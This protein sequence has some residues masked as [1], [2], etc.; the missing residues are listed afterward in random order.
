LLLFVYRVSGG[1]VGFCTLLAGVETVHVVVVLVEVDG[2]G[3]VALAEFGEGATGA[4]FLIPVNCI[5]SQFSYESENAHK[6]WN[7]WVREMYFL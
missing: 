2:N 6:H 3:L 1:N 5:F 7:C 4:A